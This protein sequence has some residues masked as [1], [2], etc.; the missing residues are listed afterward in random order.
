M[1]ARNSAVLE[2]D[3]SGCTEVFLELSESAL[4]RYPSK[5]TVRASRFVRTPV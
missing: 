2:G 4:V 3:K 5:I 1:I